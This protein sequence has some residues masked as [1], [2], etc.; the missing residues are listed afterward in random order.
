MK[1]LLKYSL[2]GA[3]LAAFGC[4]EDATDPESDAILQLGSA[5]ADGM[6]FVGVTDGTEVEL[7]PGA[8]GGFH[9]H[10]GFDVYGA[11]GS[12]R[13]AREARR[14][15]DEILVLRGT[16]MTLDVPETAMD[17]GWQKPKAVPSFMCPSPLGIQVYDREI[18]FS[19]SISDEDDN[20]LAEGTLRLIPRCPTGD[21][22]EFCR[23]V[24]AG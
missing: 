11:A 17:S 6:G 8:Q 12:L 24:C 3:A 19:A 23:E 15:E 9:V 22:Q 21:Q 16:P 18:E 7:I 4:A 2:L 13:L 20:V 1:A 14:V 10:I 5:D